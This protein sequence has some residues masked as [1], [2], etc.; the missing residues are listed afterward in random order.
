MEGE[1]LVVKIC[2]S[3]RRESYSLE[4]RQFRRKIVNCTTFCRKNFF[5][6]FANITIA[7]CWKLR[8]ERNHPD[9]ERST[10]WFHSSRFY[11]LNKLFKWSNHSLCCC[12]GL[13]WVNKPIVGSLSACPSSSSLGWWDVF[14]LTIIS[15]S[16]PTKWDGTCGLFDDVK[17]DLRLLSALRHKVISYDNSKMENLFATVVGN[18][19]S[20]NHLL[21]EVT[22]VFCVHQHQIQEISHRKLF[23]YITHRWSE[24]IAGQKHPDWYAFTYKIRTKLEEK[25]N[26]ICDSTNLLR[27]LRPLFRTWL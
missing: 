12:C 2:W 25:C 7:N 3:E 9:D 18:T 8:S 11:E 5:R 6:E 4:R 20:A 15:P 1:I 27:E 24:I 22:T 26:S 16:D 19:F 17:A 13:S 21:L 23:I 10:N 14:C